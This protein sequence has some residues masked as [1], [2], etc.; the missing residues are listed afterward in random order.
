MSI[1]QKLLMATILLTP[2]TLWL[3]DRAAQAFWRWWRR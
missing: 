2:P 1:E 3:I